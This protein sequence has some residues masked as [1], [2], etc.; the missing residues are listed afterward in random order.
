MRFY[1]GW[2]KLN[3]DYKMNRHYDGFLRVKKKDASAIE[4]L[5]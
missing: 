2:V 1:L 5:A 3:V 4:C